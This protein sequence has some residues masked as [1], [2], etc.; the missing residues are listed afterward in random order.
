MS[1]R[2][3]GRAS[4]RPAPALDALGANRYSPC[5]DDPRYPIGKAV[6]DKEPTPEKRA[7]CIRDIAELPALLRGAVKGLTDA[8]LDT[9][10]RDGGWTV[11][12]LVH[13]V[14]DSHMNAFIRFKLALTE[15]N[16]A[17][18][19]YNQDAWVTTADAALGV[20]TSLAVLDGVHARLARL[21]SSMDAAAFARTFMHPENGL[22]SLD[23]NLQIYAWHGKHHAAHVTALRARKGWG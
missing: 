16:P 4:A 11:R 3:V 2:R 8:Q 15:Q 17:I 12:Q 21:L 22:T 10:Y 6:I 5:M 20:E 1:I 9:P 14:A 13:H 19:P 7:A 18:K 23:R